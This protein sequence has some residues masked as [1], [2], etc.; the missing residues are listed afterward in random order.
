MSAAI[1]W[2]VAA[3]L[4][5]GAVA[6]LAL[7]GFA[8][9]RQAARTALHGGAALMAAL[10]YVVM[11]RGAAVY[12]GPHPVDTHHVVWLLT[13]PVLA[14]SLLATA[15]PAGQA[16]LPTALTVVF[17]DVAMVATR[18]VAVGQTGAAAWIWFVVS[19]L[20]MGLMFA[21]LRGPVR[22]AAVASGPARLDVYERHARILM[23]LWTMWPA[24]ALLGPS[25]LDLIG[26]AAQQG[27]YGLVDLASL[28][29]FSLVMVLEDERLVA[30][31]ASAETAQG[32]P[33]L[34]KV[35]LSARALAR[36]RLLDL[37][38]RGTEATRGAV[39]QGEARTR[40]AVAG[41]RPVLRRALDRLDRRRPEPEPAPPPPRRKRPPRRSIADQLAATPFGRLTKDDA[42]PIAFVAGALLVI[43]N[44]ARLKKKD[45]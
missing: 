30:L 25:L 36:E 33:A 28:A 35:P 12:V 24:I 21:L 8:T 39:R 3:G 18:A 20:T 38:D 4:A 41:A 37:V 10:Y 29:A 27:L 19:L 7:G 43:A 45:P 31:E 15:V 1:E 32:A 9:P 26:P 5:I 44:A 40:R 11:A 16:L 17:L 23:V 13:T 2:V 34:R 42:V 6:I 14:A 22:E